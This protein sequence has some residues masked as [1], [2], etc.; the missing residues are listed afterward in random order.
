MHIHQKR[1]VSWNVHHLNKS[2]ETSETGLVY[3]ANP[4]PGSEEFMRTGCG[5][6]ANAKRV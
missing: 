5:L 2:V 4:I 6:D 3:E 1:D